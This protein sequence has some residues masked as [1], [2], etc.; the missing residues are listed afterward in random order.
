MPQSE[1]LGG[2][3][4]QDLSEA[5]GARGG[6]GRRSGGSSLATTGEARTTDSA[7]NR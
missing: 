5:L 3:R 4:G 2:P 6:A 7:N 1:E